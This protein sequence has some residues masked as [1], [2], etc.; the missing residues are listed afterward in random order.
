MS[1]DGGEAG[2]AGVFEMGVARGFETG[3]DGELPERLGLTVRSG[4]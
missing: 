3:L 4:D 2:R 1:L